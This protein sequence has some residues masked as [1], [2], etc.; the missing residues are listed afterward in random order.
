MVFNAT[1]NDIAVILWRSVLL[2]REKGVTRE[3]LQTAASH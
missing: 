2:A 1:L 3:N